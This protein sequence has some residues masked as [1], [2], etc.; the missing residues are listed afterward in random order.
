MGVRV[1]ATTSVETTK[2]PSVSLGFSRF[3][4][5]HLPCPSLGSQR[6]NN[7][8]IMNIKILCMFVLVVLCCVFMTEAAPQGRPGRPRFGGG[9]GNGRRRAGP[10]NRGTNSDRGSPFGLWRGSDQ[11][12]YGANGR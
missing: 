11:D 9:F 5:L 12:G 4:R 8:F 10:R 1:V 3:H 7:L 6:N 2:N